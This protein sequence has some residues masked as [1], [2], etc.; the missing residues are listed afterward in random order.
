MVHCDD[1]SFA[2]DDLMEENETLKKQISIHMSYKLTDDGTLFVNRNG[3]PHVFDYQEFFKLSKENRT[4]L[5]KYSASHHR[6]KGNED[7]LGEL[8]MDVLEWFYGFLSIDP[9][10]FSSEE[11]RNSQRKIVYFDVP[12]Q[13]AIDLRNLLN[14]DSLVNL[15]FDLYRKAHP[16]QNSTDENVNNQIVMDKKEV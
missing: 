7:F 13:T 6:K 12:K 1:A 15:M 8:F 9:S 14:Q 5:N 3:K 16:T 4:F 10:H 2:G 11:I